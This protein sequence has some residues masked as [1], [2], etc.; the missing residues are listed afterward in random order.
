[1][2]CKDVIE[3]HNECLC[4]FPQANGSVPTKEHVEKV[5]DLMCDLHSITRSHHCMPGWAK[6]FVHCLL[7]QLGCSLHVVR[8]EYLEVKNL[9]KNAQ[10]HYSV[11]S[12]VNSR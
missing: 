10:N 7:D 4:T 1:M 8:V 12:T 11:N 9:P 6:L 2:C 3:M 5:L